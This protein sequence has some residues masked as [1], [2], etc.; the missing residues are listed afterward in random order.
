[1]NEELRARKRANYLH[2]TQHAALSH[3]CEWIARTFDHHPYLV[4]SV[5]Y[6]QDWRDV[7]VR[8]IL[9]DDEFDALPCD[10]MVLNVAFSVWG[11]QVTGLPIDFQFQRRTEANAEF[12]GGRH[13]LGLSKPKYVKALGEDQ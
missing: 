13:A 3:W 4:G 8:M 10:P 11:Q 7:D 1:M 2:V 6:R 9:D 12:G 5:L